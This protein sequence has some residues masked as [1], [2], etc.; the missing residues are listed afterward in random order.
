LQQQLKCIGFGEKFFFLLQ[1]EEVNNTY[2]IKS[3]KKI[4]K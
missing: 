4:R 3:L 2:L 1:Q